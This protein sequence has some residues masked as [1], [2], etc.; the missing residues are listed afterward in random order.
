VKQWSAAVF[1]LQTQ[2]GTVREKI[3]EKKVKKQNYVGRNTVTNRVRLCGMV[4]KWVEKRRAESD[5]F[6][7]ASL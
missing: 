6:K 3:R 2:N 7:I 1:L 5:K 4:L